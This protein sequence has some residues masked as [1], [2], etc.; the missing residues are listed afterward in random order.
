M[1]PLSSTSMRVES[2][3][4]VRSDQSAE[5]QLCAFPVVRAQEC[6]SWSWR[7]V[8]PSQL[9]IVPLGLAYNP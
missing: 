3:R 8:L 2:H 7:R 4:R 1:A 9:T 5:A 6:R